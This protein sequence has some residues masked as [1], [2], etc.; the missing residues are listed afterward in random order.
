MRKAIRS[1]CSQRQQVSPAISSVIR[2]LATAYTP[3]RFLKAYGGASAPGTQ[4]D[5]P[6][7]NAGAGWGQSW[8]A[9][10]LLLGVVGG[11]LAGARRLLGDARAGAEVGLART[12]E[13]G[14]Q[15]ITPLFGLCFLL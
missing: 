9:G 11:V 6:A 8:A 1:A 13:F 4:K 12:R 7:G 14:A 10:D 5:A 15:T 3:R 2:S